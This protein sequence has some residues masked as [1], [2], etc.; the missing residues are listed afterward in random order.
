[1]NVAKYTPADLPTTDASYDS[2]GNTLESYKTYRGIDW[3][4]ELYRL[5]NTQIHNLSVRGGSQQTKYAISGSI[6]DQRGVILNTGLSRYQ[7]R[8]SLDQQLTK[9]LDASL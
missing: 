4:D 7:G 2:E 3:Q 1:T 9:K 8:I 5:G 6:Y